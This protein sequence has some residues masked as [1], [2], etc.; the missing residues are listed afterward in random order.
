[1]CIQTGTRGMHQLGSAVF[2]HSRH[3]CRSRSSLFLGRARDL[4]FSR[5]LH[6]AKTSHYSSRNGRVR[7]KF[8][9][10]RSSGPCL[11]YFFRTESGLVSFFLVPCA[12]ILSPSFEP[13]HMKVIV[14]AWPNF[15]ERSVKFV[16]LRHIFIDR[17]YSSIKH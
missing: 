15:F 3:S 7:P 9:P 13:A 11:T 14:S 16:L 12:K 2:F 1:M 5:G 8:F 10:E 6:G 17:H 4:L